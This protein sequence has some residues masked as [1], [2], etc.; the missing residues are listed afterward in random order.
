M[1]TIKNSLENG[2]NVYLRGFGTFFIKHRAEKAA[3]IISK[4]KAIIIP[5]HLIP[6]F[7]PNKEFVEIV[8]IANNKD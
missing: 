4:D 7:K 1:W 6:Y 2:E 5:A 8:K 3:R